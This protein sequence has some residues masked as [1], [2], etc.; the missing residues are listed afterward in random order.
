MV[1]ELSGVYFVLIKRPFQNRYNLSVFELRI[2]QSKSET[3]HVIS[4]PN[5][6]HE[7]DL[8]SQV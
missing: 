1:I 5:K 8:K 2:V 3:I 7:F 6:Q 4:K